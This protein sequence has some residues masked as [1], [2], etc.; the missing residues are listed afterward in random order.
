LFFDPVNPVHPVL[1][2]MANTNPA[3][4]MRDF[5]PSDV[6]KRNYVI[7]IIKEVYES[8]GFEPL[9]TPA[10][11]NL[12]TLMGK[13]GDEG[14]QLIFKILKRGEKLRDSQES[15]VDSREQENSAK[16][17]H[18]VDLAL[19]YDLTVPLARVVANNKNELP[20]F[21]KRYQI[22]PVWRADRPA[23]GRFR[24]FY[25][26]DVDCIGTE[27][28]LVEIEL[29]AAV[30]RILKQ[31]KF[32]DF[33]IRINHRS[34]L[35]GLLNSFGVETHRHADALVSLDKLD[36]IGAEGVDDELNARGINSSSSSKLLSLITYFNEEVSLSQRTKL[37]LAEMISYLEM[38]KRPEGMFPMNSAVVKKLFSD[39]ESAFESSDDSGLIL[40]NVKTIE[41]L[42]SLLLND[43]T[44]QR[45]LDEL[46]FIWTNLNSLGLLEH[47]RIDPSLAR[48]LS[49]YT[50]T[51]MEINVP[52]LAGSLGGGGRYDG[53]I[54]MFG[55]EQIPACGFS[56][57]LERIL[58]VMDERNM[59]PA[60]VAA[61]S[62]DV[63]VTIWNEET[64]AESL[65]LA[66]DLRSQGRRVLVYPEADKLGKQLKY[67]DTIN[68]PWVCVLGD[69]EIAE[70]KVTLKNMS[71]G[72]Q[73]TMTRDKIAEEIK[74]PTV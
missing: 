41:G 16:D 19:R 28:K 20:K 10:V 31:L 33:V 60:E 43:K 34:V 38:L 2:F 26:C 29:I 72:D 44:G 24:E 54:G 4:G 12:E 50:G 47:L 70:N 59:F 8:Y 11:E 49:Y 56:L 21:F 5:L 25:Q 23:R 51:I 40:S 36:K 74:T 42:T 37:G 61:T 7:G 48:G 9:E 53:L 71:S 46:S 39:N 69:S 64:I 3:R 45:A 18:L 1:F 68:V 67:A 17:A 58:V 57:G 13:Y 15:G 65:K 55:K 30:C 27:S 32:N 63:M 66:S 62:A 22:Q 35:T 73:K 52:D 6:R 14:N